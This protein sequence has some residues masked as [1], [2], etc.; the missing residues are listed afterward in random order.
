VSTQTTDHVIFASYGNDSIALIQWMA[1]NGYT[2]CY[3]AYS[4]TGWASP[5][6]AE[7]VDAGERLARSLGMIP[8]RI[9]SM[10][11][12]PLARLKKAFPRNGM[13]FCTTELKIRPATAWLDT[14]DPDVE[15][16]CVVGVRR[17]ESR[18]RQR[19]PEYTP[20]SDKHGG[21]DLWAPMVRV[22]EKERDAL[23]RQ[24]GFEVLPHRSMECYPCVNAN[25]ADL[26]MLSD[27][28][29]AEIAEIEKSMGFTSKG[30]PRTM[31]RPYR[32]GGAVGIEEVKRWAD[33]DRGQYEPPA[34]GCDSGMCG[35]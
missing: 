30:K 10:G 11:F 4:D 5:D 25:R 9:S 20:D 21:R 32:H 12:V 23:V 7:R 1:N 22:L 13:Q 27:E 18:S 35:L 15:L 34:G 6:W 33:S 31:F 24:A 29:V 19:W 14:V 16:T 28:R 2:S 17:E 8:V 26:R 3:V